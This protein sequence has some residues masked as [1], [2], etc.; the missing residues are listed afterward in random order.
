[1]LETLNLKEKTAIELKYLGN[2]YAEIASKIDVA[3]STIAEWFATGGKLYEDY[4]AYSKKMNRLRDKTRL[5]EFV[6]LDENIAKVT[7]NVLRQFAQQLMADGKRLMV[8]NENN[9]PILD[10]N[11]QPTVYTF[12]KNLTVRD[13]VAAWKMQ[14]IL[15]GRDT[16][17]GGNALGEYNKEKVEEQ[18]ERA[19]RILNAK[20]G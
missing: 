1:M 19:R 20:T 3:P 17:G 6:E 8:V 9:S 15:S 5:A 14:R 2:S 10:E 4:L 7:T 16:N 11:G 18:I 12:S 13:M